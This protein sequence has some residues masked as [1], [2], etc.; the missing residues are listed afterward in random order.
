MEYFAKRFYII[1][2][3]FQV[4]TMWKLEFSS[5]KLFENLDHLDKFYSYFTPLFWSMGGLIVFII[6]LTGIFLLKKDWKKGVSVILG[7]LFIIIVLG[8]NKVNDNFDNIFLSSTRMF[9]GIPLFMGVVFFWCRDMLKISDTSLKYGLMVLA[10]TT[11][12]IKSSLFSLVIKE[13]TAISKDSPI[14]I[15]NINDLKC[16]CSDIGSIA[17]SNN[18]SLVIFV[19][20][21]MINAAS[22]E[23]YNYGCPQ[24]VNDFPQ[25]MMNVFERRTWVYN[26]EAS[27]VENNVLLYGYEIDAATSKSFVNSEVISLGNITIIKGNKMKTDALLKQL[28]L[29]FRRN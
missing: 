5:N 9:L 6:F 22:M 28:H 19:P 12:C 1:H 21:A 20:N 4:H 17:K 2:K 18:V 23:F 15:R 16:H 24:L 3:E 14:A 29:D 11:F 7:V 13:H 27:S 10:I 25:S 8:V 26:K